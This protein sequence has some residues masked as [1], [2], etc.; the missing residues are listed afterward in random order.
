VTF[1]EWTPVYGFLCAGLSRKEDG[2]Q[3]RAY[4]EALKSFPVTVVREA[5]T[6]AISRTWPPTHPHAG[7]VAECCTAVMRSRSVPASSCDVCH[8]DKFTI[9]QCEGWHQV[10]GQVVPVNR[11]ALCRRDFPHA[12]HEDAHFCWQC[13]PAARATEPAA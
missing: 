5:V 7:D 1:D 6:I 3:A 2:K 8:G 10:G 4:W 13:H 9:A 12:A 11:Q